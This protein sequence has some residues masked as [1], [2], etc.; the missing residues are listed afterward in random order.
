MKN[1]RKK[2][3]AYVLFTG[4]I[5]LSMN[6]KVYVSGQVMDEGNEPIA[7]AVIT[8]PGTQ[9]YTMSA[10]DGVFKI[11]VPDYTSKI[12][13]SYLGYRNEIITLNGKDEIKVNM[14]PNY[15][16]QEKLVNNGLGQMVPESAYT[17]A[18]SSV[19]ASAIGKTPSVGLDQT[20][21]GRLAGLTSLQ[22]SSA[23]GSDGTS[24]FIRGIFSSNGNAIL[25]VLDGV[26]APTLSPNTIDPNTI[27]SVTLLKDAAAKALY[28]PLGAQGVLL[29]NTKQ[30]RAGKTEVH[31]D[32]NFGI[33]GYTREYKPLDSYTYAT[34]RNEA[35]SNDGLPAIYTPEQL[36]AFKNQGGVNNNWKDMYYKKRTTT[37]IY[38]VSG[39]GGTERIQFYLN[40]GFTHQDGIYEADK[41]GKFDPRPYYNRFTT[42]SNVKVN[43][44]KY[45]NAGL[46]TNVRIYRNNGSNTDTSSI[47]EGIML[48]P[49]TVPGPLSDDGKIVTTENFPNPVY[50][51]INK[52]GY[53][54]STG[55]D[56]N[57]NF[58]LDLDMGFLT[59]GLSANAMVGYHSYYSGTI[60]GT[61]DYTRYVFDQDGNTVPFGSNAD[62]PLSLGKSSNTVYSMNVQGSLL[63]ERTF[64][65]KLKVN[66]LANYLAED[67]I[68]SSFNSKYVLPYRRIQF[69][70]QLHLGW[71]NKYFIQG[72]L[73]DAGSEEFRKGNQYHIS[74][75]ISGAWNVS[76]EQFMKGIKWLDLL[77]VRASYGALKY[78]NIYSIGRLLYSSE[79]RQENGSGYINS[80]YTAALIKEYLLGNA[81]ITWETSYQ[82]NYGIDF[83]FL[84]SF[85]ASFDYWK[86]SQ[87]GV[88]GKDF[89]KPGI[90]GI[91]SDNLPYENIG[92]I[93][94]QGVD[95]T[96][97]YSRKLNCGLEMDITGIFGYN[98]NKVISSGEVDL[99]SSGYAYPYRTTGYALGK[100]FGYIVDYSNGNGFFNTQ[101][102]LDNNKLIY[103]GMKAPRLG[104]LKYKD[105]NNDGVINQKDMAPLAGTKMIPSYD[106][107]LNIDMAYK[108]FD[109]S[110]FWQGNAGKAAFYN[111]PGIHEDWAQGTYSPIHQ[112]AWTAERY[113]NG[114][115]ILYPAL[116]AGGASSLEVNNF[117]ISKNDFVRLKNLII[118]YSLPEK[119]L[120]MAHL[121]KVRLFLSGENLLTFTNFKFKNI[122]PE[123]TNIDTYPVYKTFNIGLNINF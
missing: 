112:S 12:T 77:K 57:A 30:G 122:D 99:S 1:I 51:K 18:R 82:Q 67:R 86:T 60:D 113:A 38:N 102:E 64:L 120:N 95:L 94:S 59:K 83:C 90:T 19:Y 97:E 89:S 4:M 109:F 21:T 16:G 105:L 117:L 9:I 75:T 106:Y 32:L 29:I 68:S 108:G 72:A 28:G 63:F 7:G 65:N 101:E 48:T 15:S 69:A 10:M 88:I 24:K 46:N 116:S 119:I 44:F 35:L 54:K 87:N 17:G 40:T 98:T 31:A 11:S 25:C 74:P 52:T 53:S 93:R 110:M 111:G 20:L 55:T 26:P 123:Q 2:I 71:D 61:A 27:E 85:K 13:C 103:E 45:L 62:S 100:Q 96:L 50:G 78:D 23:P 70:G 14:V 5:T 6:A 73:T 22:G 91:N 56:V 81:N 42:V 76:N 37:Q 107:S 92:K 49:A 47:L 3:L 79:I 114:E 34:L 41:N 66:A 121:T 39:T 80:L 43:V 36:E 8:V 104:D 118:G 115:K 33:N 84:N 58:N